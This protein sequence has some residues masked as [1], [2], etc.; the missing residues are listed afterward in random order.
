MK[1]TIK[2]KNSY[3]KIISIF[4]IIIGFA[5]LIYMIKVENEP[6]ALPLLLILLG[7]GWFMVIQFLTPKKDN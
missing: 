6:G 7:I 5:L 4:I 1:L 3:Q 2:N